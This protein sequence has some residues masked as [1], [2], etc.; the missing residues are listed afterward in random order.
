MNSE[1][2]TVQGVFD[3]IR[4]RRN[5][6]DELRELFKMPPFDDTAYKPNSI[7]L[8]WGFEFLVFEYT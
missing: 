8:V 2:A 1:K 4:R 6:V 5:G 3:D 7:S